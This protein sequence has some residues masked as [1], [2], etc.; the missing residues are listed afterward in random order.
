MKRKAINVL[1]RLMYSSKIKEF[2][3][4][5]ED[6]YK[7]DWKDRPWEAYAIDC[8]K[9]ETENKELINS[10]SGTQRME[11]IIGLQA[12]YNVKKKE[13]DFIENKVLSMPINEYRFLFSSEYE[14]ILSDIGKKDLN[15]A[16][17]LYSEFGQIANSMEIKNKLMWKYVCACLF[18]SAI[19]EVFGEKLN[20]IENNLRNL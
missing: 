19:N 3:N 1:G 2:E 17:Q 14:I 4:R 15:T 20:K 13:L 12:L 11:Y 10:S 9:L 7:S 8:F 18:I 5:I 16:V 6:T